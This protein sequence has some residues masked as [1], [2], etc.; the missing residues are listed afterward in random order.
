VYPSG[1]SGLS[2]SIRI[3]E[4]VTNDLAYHLLSATI[5]ALWAACLALQGQCAL[6]FKVFQELEIALFSVT[7]FTSGLSGTQSL[8][9][10]FEK[11]G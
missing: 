4:A 1:A 8:A 6:S 5:I 10:A 3:E 2:R 9:L 7:E 11:H